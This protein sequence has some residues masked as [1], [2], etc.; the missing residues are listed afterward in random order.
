VRIG[1]PA[2]TSRGF[3]TTDFDRVADLIVQVLAATTPTSTRSGA[4]SKAKYTITDNLAGNV[5]DA[6]HELLTANPSTPASKSPL[7]ADLSTQ[8]RVCH[9]GT[10]AVEDA[11]CRDYRR[12][13]S[14]CEHPVDNCGW[15]R[16]VLGPA[17]PRLAR[18]RRS[19]GW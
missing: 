13:L 7:S 11:S 10:E 6:A 2:L 17:E 16:L 18:C 14:D 3:G 12:R 19:V 4:T 1:T 5:H 8:S 9:G 15:V